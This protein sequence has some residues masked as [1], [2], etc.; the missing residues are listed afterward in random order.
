M[1]DSPRID[2][3]SLLSHPNAFTVHVPPMS[4]TP[5]SATFTPDHKSPPSRMRHVVIF[6]AVLMSIILYLDRYCVS[7]SE[8]YIKED[9]ALSEIQMGW[10]ISAF[11]WTYALAQVPAG[12]LSDR[13][14]SRGVLAMYIVA[15]SCF[16]AMIGLAA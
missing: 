9:L 14:G 2:Q 6:V 5:P 7:F 8:R 13:L 15:W 3:E 1:S 16:T 11:F 4:T 10:F 12:W